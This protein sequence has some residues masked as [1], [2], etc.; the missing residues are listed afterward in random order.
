MPP[1]DSDKAPKPRNL[2]DYHRPPRIKLGAVGSRIPA[3]S[4][5]SKRSVQGLTRNSACAHSLAPGKMS[6]E[7][8]SVQGTA[9]A[10]TLSADTVCG[11]ISRV[12]C[13]AEGGSTCLVEPALLDAEIV[14]RRYRAARWE[15]RSG[16]WI[17]GGCR[18][19]RSLSS[20]DEDFSVSKRREAFEEIG[21]P[22]DK[23]KV[24]LLCILSP[25]VASNYLVVT[26]V[27]V[28][29]LDNTLRPIL[30]T[31]EV[32]SLFSHPLASFLSSSPPF[33][34]EPE[35]VE[36]PY[37]T[38]SDWRYP[39]PNGQM[40]FSR[41]HRFLTGREAGGIKPVF[42][43]TAAILID[44]ACIAHRRAPDFELTHPEGMTR[45]ARLAWIVYSQPAFRTA[46]EA[47]G[48]EV[49]WEQIRRLAG[50]VDDRGDIDRKG[51]EKK[52]TL[53]KQRRRIPKNKSKL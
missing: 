21:L 38:T 10:D 16:R 23:L 17:I 34:T 52:D 30:N 28:L 9:G 12:V 36:V 44:A 15:G 40:Y 6:A 43:L 8:F 39:G 7:P 50:V 51:D 3:L 42:G 18:G 33:S 47:E 5:D 14:C 49:D 41:G 22:A 2:R 27:V 11:C 24:P 25:V 4:A 31:A 53:S 29:I 37:H 19:K 20:S 13:R 48:I 26:P 35:L 46:Y 1:P 32:A 45:E